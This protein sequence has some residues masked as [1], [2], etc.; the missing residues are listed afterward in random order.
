MI[1]Q[2]HCDTLELPRVLDMLADCCGCDDSRHLARQLSPAESYESAIRLLNFT[3]AANTLSNRFGY[4]AVYRMVNCAGALKRAQ[5]GSRLSLR[6]LLDIAL[7]LRT[8]RSL[9]NWKLQS[10]DETT[11]LDGLFECLFIEKSLESRLTDS[12]LS[13]EELDDNASALL[14]DIRRKIKNAGLK[15]RSQLDSMIRSTTYQKYLQEPIVT[16]RDGRFVVPVKAEYKSEVKGLVHDTSSSGATYF[17]E[18][19]SVVEL[20]NE[21]RVLQSKSSRRLTVSLWSF[22]PLSAALPSRFRADTTAPLR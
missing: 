20:N 16:M 2:K 9:Y 21:I 6:E 22:P 11:A 5:L 8:M 14:S 12:I 1:L 4:P 17:I 15:V 3:V 13:E 10:K 18:P 7:V 19:M